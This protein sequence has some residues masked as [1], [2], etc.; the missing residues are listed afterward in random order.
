MHFVVL[1]EFE[2]KLGEQFIGMLFVQIKPFFGQVS[3][4]RRAVIQQICKLD[5]VNLLIC[6]EVVK[7]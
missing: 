5:K 2:L 7:C 1:A 3:C 4:A 6:P